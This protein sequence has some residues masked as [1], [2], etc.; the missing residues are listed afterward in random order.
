[1]NN[2]TGSEKVNLSPPNSLLHCPYCWNELPKQPINIG[3]FPHPFLRSKDRLYRRLHNIIRPESTIENE[4][5]CMNCGKKFSITLFKKIPTSSQ[6]RQIYDICCGKQDIKYI[7]PLFERFLKFFFDR[8]NKIVSQLFHCEVFESTQKI[9][10]FIIVWFLL[11]LMLALPLALNTHMNPMK[12]LSILDLYLIL[13]TILTAI[14]VLHLYDLIESYKS[15]LNISTLKFGLHENY[16]TSNWG[17]TFEYC[18]LKAP[19]N[20]YLG[21]SN[22]LFS[23]PMM[24]GLIAS[25]PYLIYKFAF[26]IGNLSNNP[27]YPVFASMAIIPFYFVTFFI[28]G[29]SLSY[30]IIGSPV[31]KIIAREI[32]LKIDLLDEKDSYQ[33]LGALLEKSGIIFLLITSIFSVIILGMYASGSITFNFSSI[34]ERLILFSLLSIIFFIMSWLWIS[35]LLDLKDKYTDVK[36]QYCKSL[37]KEYQLIACDVTTKS[38]DIIRMMDISRQIDHI[39]SKPK[40]PVERPYLLSILPLIS[41]IIAILTVI[42]KL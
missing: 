20:E 12:D 7:I 16:A 4:T 35:S 39:H 3:A 38:N 21:T 28:I 10:N 6:S 36:D 1:M 27:H 22:H 5:K 26:V 31:T 30:S 37:R 25:A 2:D 13:V 32:D 29:Y 14:L 23:R 34:Y 17:K 11:L 41:P 8:S 9:C 33:E 18:Y 40:W 19:T 15:T 24:V 42:Q